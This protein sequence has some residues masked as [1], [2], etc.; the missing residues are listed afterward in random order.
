M[1]DIGFGWR[2]A[3]YEGPEAQTLLGLFTGAN[4]VTTWDDGGT[5]YSIKV[6]PLFPQQEPC[7]TVA[8][9]G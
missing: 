1:A 3:S 8:S 4:Q 7:T 5:E 9:A 6:R 2:C